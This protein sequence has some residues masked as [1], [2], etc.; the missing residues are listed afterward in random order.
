MTSCRIRLPRRQ[1][2]AAALA[3]AVLPGRSRAETGLL[4]LSHGSLPMTVMR[5]RFEQVAAPCL[6][7]PAKA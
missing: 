7:P 1:A 5:V 4:R 3:G 2:L 6:S